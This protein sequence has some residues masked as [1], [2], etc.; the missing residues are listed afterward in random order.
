MT[1]HGR[2]QGQ[3]L[4]YLPNHEK[5]YWKTGPTSSLRDAT[6]GS[7]SDN[8][9]SK[10]DTGYRSFIV[11]SNRSEASNNGCNCKRFSATPERK[12][13]LVSYWGI[14]PQLVRCLRSDFAGQTDKEKSRKCLSAHL[15]LQSF[16]GYT[17][18]VNSQP[19]DKQLYY[20]SQAFH[21][22]LWTTTSH[23]LRYWEYLYWSWEM[24][25]RVRIGRVSPRSSGTTWDHMEIQFE[26][27][28]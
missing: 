2:I 19:G 5:F 17:S 21:H 25:T 12:Q 24:A 6:W 15:H 26:L 20:M 16:K 23:L 1:C 22:S 11:W 14:G 27:L 18:R 7:R 8:G 4:I 3:T 28:R 10:R 13:H 9:S